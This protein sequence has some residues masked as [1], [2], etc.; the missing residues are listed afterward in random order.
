MLLGFNT[1]AIGTKTLPLTGCG[2]QHK[3][4]QQAAASDPAPIT[5]I[6]KGLGSGMGSGIAYARKLPAE[7]LQ[8]SLTTCLTGEDRAAKTSSKTCPCWI[9]RQELH[10]PE[11]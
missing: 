2:M 5:S 11:C 9:A 7:K 4:Q 6:E 10:T 1:G 8:S 3:Q